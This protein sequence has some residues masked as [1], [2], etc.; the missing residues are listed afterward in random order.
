[1]YMK[2]ILGENVL[3]HIILEV[4]STLIFTPIYVVNF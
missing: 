1:M 3:T 2:N 4:Y